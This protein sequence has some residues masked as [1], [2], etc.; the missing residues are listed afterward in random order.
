ME[1]P[2]P[3]TGVYFSPQA[4]SGRGDIV[5]GSYFEHGGIG[6][7]ADPHTWGR[8]NYAPITRAMAIP[9]GTAVTA[10]VGFCGS[11]EEGVANNYD[12]TSSPVDPLDEAAVDTTV[13][14]HFAPA[15]SAET[16]QIS[17][18]DDTGSILPVLDYESEGS[19]DLASDG[20]ATPAHIY[21]TGE[22]ANSAAAK[23]A[24][25]NAATAEANAQK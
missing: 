7:V 19:T 3:G 17:N 8:P 22:A 13:A 10:Y 14:N 1:S 24:A 12:D 16:V 11:D 9:F 21:M 25:T 6:Y 5:T 2:E 18:D 4:M 15:P 23:P 20:T